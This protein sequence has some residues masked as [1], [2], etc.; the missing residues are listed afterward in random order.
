MP[1]EFTPLEHFQHLLRRWTWIALAIFLGS[2][3]AY[4]Y[5][6]VQPPIY[7]A[8]TRFYVSIDYDL[9]PFESSPIDTYQYN[10]DLALAAVEGVMLSQT[11][12]KA[13]IAQANEL[14][15]P[16]TLEDLA[17][18]GDLERRHT[19]W[20]VRYR[21]T[22][23]ALARQV[24]ELWAAEGYKIIQVWQAEGT[25]ANF[26]LF[27][28]PT[29]VALPQQPSVFVRGQLMTAGALIGLV[30]GILVV[31]LVDG[32][33]KISPAQEPRVD[34]KIRQDH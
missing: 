23:P 16:L 32:R 33:K 7:E 27:D 6:R 14:G 15:I 3:L 2:S 25:I 24:M 12:Q 22:D 11:V 29:P 13:V 17:S 19:Y 26:V 34:E 4:L 18:H 21:S 28:P 8:K 9:F 1:D 20:E 31:T 10:E 30:V 5:H